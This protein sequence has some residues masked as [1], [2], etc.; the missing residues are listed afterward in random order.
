[1]TEE[2]MRRAQEDLLSG[3]LKCNNGPCEYNSGKHLLMPNTYD[4]AR[5]GAICAYCWEW[6]GD[7]A[8]VNGH[9]EEK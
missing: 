4:F 9:T 2:E 3:K 7:L 6:V 8:V 1:M 5:C